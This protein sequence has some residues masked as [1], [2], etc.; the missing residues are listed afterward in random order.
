MGSLP[1]GK[2]INTPKDDFSFG[3]NSTM[4]LGYFSSDRLGGS[5]ADDFMLFHLRPKLVE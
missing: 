4:S 5:G 3:L 1:F 2:D